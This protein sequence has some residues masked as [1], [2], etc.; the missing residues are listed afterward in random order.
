MIRTGAQYL[1][2]LRDGRQVYVDGVLSDDVTTTPGVCEMAHTVARMFDYQHDP[3]YAPI[4]T[5]EGLDGD[6]R[7]ASWMRPQSVEDL[8]RRM[9]LTQTVARLSGGMFGRM[10]EYVPL[11]FL[12]MLDQKAAFSEGKQHFVDNI[13]RIYEHLAGND[14]TISHAFVDMQTDPAIPVD[15]TPIARITRKDEDGIYVNGIKGIATFAPQSDEILI[16]AFPR[17]GLQPHHVMYFS[18]PVATKGLKVVAR[19][20]YVLGNEYDHPGCRFGDEND[21]IVIL[22]DVFVP[23]ERVFQA[24]C[25]PSFANRTFP[26]ITEWAHWSILCRLA[27]KAEILVGVFSALPEA[28]GRS[29]RPDAQE[30]LGEMERYLITLRSFIDAA[31]YRGQRTP[32]GHFMP[33]PGIVTAG[34]CYSVE[35]YPRLVDALVQLSGQAFMVVPTKGTLDSPDVGAEITAMF[36]SPTVS[37]DERVRLTRFAADL[38]VSS[39]G[40]RQTLF[41]IFNATGVATIR[42][43]LMGRFD[44]DPYKGIAKATAGLGSLEDAEQALRAHADRG[45]FAEPSVYDNVGTAYAS[46]YKDH[47]KAKA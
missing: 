5:M 22:E 26:L 3:E 2:G 42:S 11:F 8:Q 14:L 37:A 7:S 4:F 41:E 1:A 40:G 35:H 25:D 13:E 17:V 28:L 45:Y 39:Y 32:G 47:R 20:A 30:K 44:L 36:E 46:S 16:G 23:W 34:R 38:T 24:E 29:A 27:A 33:D 21:A 9:Q 15:E 18:V 6:V 19:E 10:P 31:A 12:G 43:Q